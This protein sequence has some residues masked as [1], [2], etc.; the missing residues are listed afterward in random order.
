MD[1]IQVPAVNDA[2][3]NGK[4]DSQDAQEALDAAEDL[5]QKQRKPRRLQKMH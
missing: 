3:G 4:P 2:D 1:G 5:V